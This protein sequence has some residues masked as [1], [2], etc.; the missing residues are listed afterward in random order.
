MFLSLL[1]KGERRERRCKGNPSLSFFLA[2][3]FRISAILLAYEETCAVHVVSFPPF[4][5]IPLPAS[6]PPPRLSPSNSMKPGGRIER[7][8]RRRRSN[9]ATKATGEN[10]ERRRRRNRGFRLTTLHTTAPPPLLSFKT[11]AAA[12]RR[13][14]LKGSEIP[15][16]PYTL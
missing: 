15:P 1:F 11:A 6:P 8:G 13:R 5:K 4:R 12:R 9:T 10:G 14:T 16:S 7:S 3:I 2:Q